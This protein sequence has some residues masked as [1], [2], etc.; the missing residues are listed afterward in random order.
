MM[1]RVITLAKELSVPVYFVSTAFIYR[2]DGSTEFNNAYE[3]DKSNAERL[4]LESGLEYCIFRPSV[5]TGHSKT[6]SVRNFSGYYLVARAFVLAAQSAKARDRS[7]RFP[8]MRGESNIIPVD[9]VAKAIGEAVVSGARGTFYLTN[10]SAPQSEWVLK[11]TLKFF[12][13]QDDVIIED[14]PFQDF[15]NL[16]L[17]PEEAAL[18]TFSKHFSPYWSIEYSFPASIC[19]ENRIDHEYMKRALTFFRDSDNFHGKRNH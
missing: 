7:L 14:V 16:D 15:V 11:E 12:G 3:K 10:T 5:L 9:Q 8:R 17:T 1:R 13:F 4:L 19:T 6:G 18:Y 2:P